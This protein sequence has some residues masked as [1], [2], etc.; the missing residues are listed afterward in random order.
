VSFVDARQLLA[1][2]YRVMTFL[3][4]LGIIQLAVARSSLTGLWLVTRRVMVPRIGWFLV[5]AGV[6]LYLLL[7][8]WQTGPW[9]TVA[10]P[11][12]P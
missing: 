5:V 7:P 12:T 4:S 9:A 8:L 3:V 1:F 2:D 11:T 6:L 10:D